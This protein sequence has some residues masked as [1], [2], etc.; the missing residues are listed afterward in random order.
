M[1]SDVHTGEHGV[2]VP[3]LL[4]EPHWD[5]S[6]LK[7]TSDRC[8][9]ELRA[10]GLLRSITHFSN[11]ILDFVVRPRGSG[12]QMPEYDE[13]IVN[14]S[15]GRPGGQLV[16]CFEDLDHALG[17]LNTGEL[18]R[19]VVATPS[20]SLYCG[21]VKLRLHL[22]GIIEQP[23]RAD[24]AEHLDTSMNRLLT[25]VRVE[26]HNLADEHLGGDRTLP[27]TPVA[28]TPRHEFAFEAGLKALDD[29]STELRLRS[30]WP[31]FVNCKDLHYAALYQDWSL[32]CVGDAFDDKGMSPRFMNIEPS[33]RRALYRDLAHRLR[34]DIARLRDALR[35]VTTE[36]I[37]RLVMDVQEGAIYIHWLGGRTGD[38]IL[39]VSSSTSPSGGS[40]C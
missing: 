15:E 1:T 33:R 35:P 2:V 4:K 40:A 28:P 14:E 32:V 10:S 12:I 25:R 27:V 11:G 26:V 24:G 34:S 6:K 39:G 22:V 18:M 5:D 8:E 36:P 37:N 17:E 20:G 7:S 31:G 13:D 3:Q 23:G 30:L 21:R 19:T 38:F 16:L 9:A 29:P